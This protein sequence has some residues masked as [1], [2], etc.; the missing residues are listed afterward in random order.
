MY[1]QTVSICIISQVLLSTYI[2]T[3]GKANNKVIVKGWVPPTYQVHHDCKCLYL[4]RCMT[5]FVILHM[6]TCI[7]SVHICM[8]VCGT[9]KDIHIHISKLLCKHTVHITGG[10]IVCLILLHIL[11]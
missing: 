11:V 7:S 2:S 3:S 4:R 10:E 6:H 5:E 9:S 1:M 8:Q